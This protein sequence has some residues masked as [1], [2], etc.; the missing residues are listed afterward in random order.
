MKV[1][2]DDNDD[3]KLEFRDGYLELFYKYGKT[4]KSIPSTISSVL[5]RKLDMLNAAVILNDVKSPPGNRLKKLNP[6]LEEY[7]SIRVNDQYRLIFKW[8]SGVKGLYLDP[9][10]D[11]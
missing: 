11:V 8:D 2:H 3:C 1:N 6:P 4:H 7:C 9:H 10:K 5:A